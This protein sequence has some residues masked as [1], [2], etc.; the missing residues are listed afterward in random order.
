MVIVCITL[1]DRHGVCSVSWSQI[2]T[3]QY[4]IHSAIISD[5]KV[6]FEAV[7]II[8][9]F[10]IFIVIIA[11]TIRPIEVDKRFFFFNSFIKFLLILICVCHTRECYIW[12]THRH[13]HTLYGLYNRINYQ[14]NMVAG[15]V[16]VHIEWGVVD[17]IVSNCHVFETIA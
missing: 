4:L 8:Q 14:K 16:C 11:T 2:V 1:S 10:H 17:F 6:I 5:G 15:F 12:I 13:T 9:L 3:C 7:K